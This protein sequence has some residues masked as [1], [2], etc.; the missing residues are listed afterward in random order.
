MDF[1]KGMKVLVTGGNGFLGRRICGLLRGHGVEPIIPRK[2]DHDL[3]SPNATWKLFEDMNPEMVIHCAATCGGIGL[4]RVAPGT[5]FYENIQ[6]GVN[7]IHMAKLFKVK[8]LVMIGTI[9]EYPKNTP[10][11]FRE[12][13]LWNGYPEETNAPYGIAK[14]AL[15]TMGQAYRQ[16]Y[17]L[18]CIHLMPVNLYGP[19]DN[20]DPQSSHVIP[21]LIKKIIDAKIGNHKE[22]SCWGTGKATREFLYV[23]DA[24]NGILK[25][26]ELYQGAA[27]IN[28]G[29]SFEITI[30][31]LAG[32]ICEIVGFAGKI[33]FDP[34]KPDG[35]PR[36]SLDSSL[37][38]NEF[39]WTAETS[40]EAGL[41]KTIEWYLKERA[42]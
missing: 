2:R 33:R 18:N 6:M 41:R 15:L 10:V 5:L 19:G 11:P 36:R 7:V 28:L 23:G 16:E 35:Q 12:K 13:D 1:W 8:K 40:F 25:A 24:A 29:A 39:G 14:K 38:Y 42:R 27:P 17:G 22:I 32:L 3:I 31:G 37:A 34:S 21:A 30:G 4:N 26:A 9:C 20:F